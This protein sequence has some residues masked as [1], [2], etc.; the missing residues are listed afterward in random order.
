MTKSRTLPALLLLVLIR[1]V[2]ASAQAGLLQDEPLLPQPGTPDQPTIVT[3]DEAIAMDRTRMR[4][5]VGTDCPPGQLDDEVIVCGRREGI[6]RYRVP[7]AD[8]VA[9]GGMRARAGDAQLYAME[10]NSQRC[11]PVGRDQMCGGGLDL[12]GIGFTIVRGITQALANRD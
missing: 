3:A 9:G 4:G 6:Q 1:P 11:S 12:L 8:P 7:I 5:L 10:A 2:P